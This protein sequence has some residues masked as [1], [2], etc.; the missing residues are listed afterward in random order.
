MKNEQN[1]YYI[2]TYRRNLHNIRR[3]SREILFCPLAAFLFTLT[4]LLIINIINKNILK[5]DAAKRRL[6]GPRLTSELWRVCTKAGSKGPCI[7]GVS[8]RI[9]TNQRNIFIKERQLLRRNYLSTFWNMHYQIIKNGLSNQLLTNNGELFKNRE[10]ENKILER[11]KR[12]GIVDECCKGE[13]CDEAFL[14]SF[15]KRF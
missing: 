4:S 6:C 5:A 9:T 1:I 11:R 13:G 8:K 15:C 12:K 2:K 14:D 3:N 7:H 10:N